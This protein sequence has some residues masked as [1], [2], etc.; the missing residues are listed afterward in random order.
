MSLLSESGNNNLPMHGLIIISA[1]LLFVA[2][3][4]HIR[5]IAAFIGM[6]RIAEY[7]QLWDT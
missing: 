1:A 4:Q 6:N 5:N 2:R 7:N 3:V